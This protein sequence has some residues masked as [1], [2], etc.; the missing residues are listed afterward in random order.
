LIGGYFVVGKKRQ[1][2]IS[3]NPVDKIKAAY[4]IIKLVSEK[5]PK[6]FGTTK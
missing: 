1:R 4:R 6:T 2:K 5:V 3:E